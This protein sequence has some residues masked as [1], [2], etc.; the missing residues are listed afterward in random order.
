MTL[1]FKHA[2][3]AL[4]SCLAVPGVLQAAEPRYTYGEIGYVNADFDDIDEDGDGYGL[5]GSYALHRNVHLLAGYQDIDLGGNNDYNSL[6]L[7][8]GANFALR[9]GLD[10]VG[11]VAW[12]N[13]EV[14]VGPINEDDDGYG[15]E[16]GVRM[17]INPQLELN[18]FAR[19]VDV[20]SEDDTSLVIGG[21]YEIARNVAVGADLEFSDDVTSFF[22]KARLYFN[23]P[24]QIR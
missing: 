21:L 9:P 8:V 17:M 23:P 18:G 4:A 22:L 10:A 3:W 11:R 1:R 5:G 19:Y 7:G 13:A 16:A 14:D 15:L 6:L 20:G 12:I 2:A 24:A